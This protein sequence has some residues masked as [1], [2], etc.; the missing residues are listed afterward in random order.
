MLNLIRY[1]SH[2]FSTKKANKMP[3][4]A[5][6]STN[7]SSQSLD[8]GICSPKCFESQQLWGRQLWS[9]WKYNGSAE[10][11]STLAPRV[12]PS[13]LFWQLA[14]SLS[15]NMP[16]KNKDRRSQD[17]LMNCQAPQLQGVHK[18]RHLSRAQTYCTELGKRE[19]CKK[20]LSPEYFQLAVLWFM[21][22]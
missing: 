14:Q 19:T 21:S 3:P 20:R 10:K 15:S 16:S 22:E 11:S 17:S 8:Q 9:P 18:D 12:R 5:V 2:S 7:L 4:S 13:S 1:Q 6:N